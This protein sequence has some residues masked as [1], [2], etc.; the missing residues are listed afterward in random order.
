MDLNAVSEFMFLMWDG[1]EFH[2]LGAEQQKAL[3]PIV[4]RRTEGTE[5]WVEEEE[6]RVPDRVTLYFDSHFIRSTN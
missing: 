1:R 3:L 4:L 5:R 6:R 2:S